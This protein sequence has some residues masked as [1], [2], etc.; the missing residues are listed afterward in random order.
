MVRLAL[1][2]LVLAGGCVA[3]ARDYRAAIACEMA[4][5]TI[6]AP[7]PAEIAEEPRP[8]RRRWFRRR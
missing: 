5:A 8:E 2:S 7:K 4:L 6:D 3:P 1:C